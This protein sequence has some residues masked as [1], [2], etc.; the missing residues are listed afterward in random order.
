MPRVVYSEDFRVEAVKQATKNGYSITD[1][2]EKLG[3]H[4]DTLRSWIKKARVPR[5]N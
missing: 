2:A 4:T 1:T 3:V 5:S